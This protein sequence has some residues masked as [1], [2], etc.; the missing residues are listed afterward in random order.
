MRKA[1]TILAV[2]ICASLAGLPSAQAGLGLKIGVEG[3]FVLP[4]SDWGDGTGIGLGGMAKGTY[5]LSDDMSLSLRA[6][7]IFHL[8]KTIDGV[9]YSTSEM[10]FLV[11]FKY[12]LPMGLF[13]E[14]ALG[15]VGVG[16]KAGDLSSDTEMKL[17]FLV[18]A[19]YSIA[20]LNLGVNL[21]VPKLG[22]IDKIMGL[23]FVVGYDFLSF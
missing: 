16:G 3:A 11:G 20:G 4:M 14:A 8:A 15:L 5:G 18:G 12:A 10:P 21:F 1:A 19:G 22:D 17:G 9:D 2:C 6:G 13:G 23:L 7:Y